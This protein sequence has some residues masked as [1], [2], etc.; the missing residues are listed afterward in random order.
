VFGAGSVGLAAIMAA[1]STAATRIIAVDRHASR[2]DL[3]RS[4]GAT[5]TVDVTVDDPVR[6]IREICGGPADFALECT[7]VISVCRQAVDSVG[8]L[9][10]CALVGGAPAG[11]ELTVDHLTTL[12]GKRIQGVLG[13]G[14]TSRRLIGTLIDLHRQGRFPFDRLISYFSLD[15][16]EDALAASYSG[17][18]LKPILRFG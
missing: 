3:A 7:G 12:W 17:E 5:D 14:G 4:F 6:S 2:L 1:R 8:M 18:V 16:I 10:T 9:G 13:G 15:D 11:T